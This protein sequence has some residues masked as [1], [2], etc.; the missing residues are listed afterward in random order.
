MPTNFTSLDLFVW[1][2]EGVLELTPKFQR[3]S[4]WSPA[5]RSFFIDSL[6]RGYPVPPLHIRMLPSA[7][8][9]RPRREVIDGQQRL[10]TIFDFMQNKIRLGR[11]LHAD[12]ANKS[13]DQLTDQDRERLKLSQF[14]VYQYQAIDDET[15]LEIF[16]RLNTYSV[17]LNKQELRNG[18]YFGEFKHLVYNLSRD[19]LGFWRSNRVFGESAIARMLEAEFVS[20]LLV[21]QFDGF[22]DKKGSLDSYYAGLDEEWPATRTKLPRGRSASFSPKAWLDSEAAEQRCRSTLDRMTEQVGDLIASTPFRHVP[23]LYTLYSVYYHLMY[24]LPGQPHPARI[25]V[26]TVSEVLSIRAAIGECAVAY[27]VDRRD[28]AVPVWERNFA[29]ASARQTDNIGPRQVRFDELWR[30][31]GVR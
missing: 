27:D 24:G 11:N 29:L 30:R 21:L 3:R 12:W 17:R 10:R 18:K 13:F 1:H 19:Y 26:P 23:L 15:V 20:E 9:E 14:H 4:V 2:E 6:L 22:Q 25:R 16:A 7:S 31:A 28:E 5:A 8:T